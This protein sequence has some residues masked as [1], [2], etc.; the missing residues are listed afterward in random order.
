MYTYLK[1]DIKGKYVDFPEPLDPALYDNIGSTWSDYI[2]GLWIPLSAEQMAFR[3]A[4]PTASVREVFNMMLTPVTPYVRTVEEAKREMKNT[5][6]I[7]DSSNEVNIF[8]IQGLEVWLDKA[9]R[10]G[11]KLRFE[12]E[13][14]AGQTE[15]TLWYNN[16]QFPLTVE[17]AI[18][19]LYAI[20]LYASACYDNTQRHLSIIETLTT[21]EEIDNYDYKTGYPDKLNF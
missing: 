15:T 11:L 14:A 6:I 13:A 10:T 2:N 4:N 21:V 3:E 17:M 8:Y 12:A 19:M 20:E 7:Y 18:Q 5:I 16:M 9:T 1:Y